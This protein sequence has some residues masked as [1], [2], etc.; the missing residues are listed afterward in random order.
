MRSHG[1]PWMSFLPRRSVPPRLLIPCRPTARMVESSMLKHGFEKMPSSLQPSTRQRTTCNDPFWLRTPSSQP[2]TWQSFMTNSPPLLRRPEPLRFEMAHERMRAS[3]VPST[4]TTPM[5][6]ATS[7]SSG[8]CPL[9][10]TLCSLVAPLPAPTMRTRRALVDLSATLSAK[11]PAA[12]RIST[13]FALGGSRPSAAATL[14]CSRG[15]WSTASTLSLPPLSAEAKPIWKLWVAA[16]RKSLSFSLTSLPSSSPAEVR[17]MVLSFLRSAAAAASASS[18]PTAKLALARRRRLLAC[19]GSSSSALLA[20]LAAAGQS[21]SR[22]QHSERL[23]R[24]LTFS[25]R[26]ASSPAFEPKWRSASSYAASAG[27]GRL[28]LKCALPLALAAIAASNALEATRAWPDGGEAAALERR[29]AAT[30]SAVRA[31]QFTSPKKPTHPPP[32]H[33]CVATH[34][35]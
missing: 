29:N 15:T 30:S 23:E 13:S 1:D 18:L 5:L 22:R 9:S 8:A 3:F 17:S 2:Y 35:S 12:T 6:T 19:E 7:V 14:A 27:A 11:V 16:C 21:S 34:T 4:T 31:S 24:I 32:A 26:C 10:S 33:W 25:C 28:A 20:L